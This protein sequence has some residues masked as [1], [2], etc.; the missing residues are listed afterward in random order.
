[1][2]YLRTLLLMS[3]L[4]PFYAFG[5][6]PLAVEDAVSEIEMAVEVDTSN[7]TNASNF[8]NVLEAIKERKA[9]VIDTTNFDIFIDEA[10]I[11]SIDNRA[12][13]I[14]A[15][16]PDFY[17]DASKY[18]SM[19]S[20]KVS[21]SENFYTVVV[22]YRVGEYEMESTLIN[23][24]SQGNIIA[25]QLVAYDEIEKGQ[26]R[27]TSRIS[28]DAITSQHSS[29]GLTKEIVVE[30]FV[31]NHDGTINKRESKNLSDTIDNDALV[32]YVLK[33]IGLAPP[34]LKTD[35]VVSKLNP[36]TPNEVIVVIPE[37][38]DE[39]EEYFELNSHIV[40]ADNRSG[41]VSHHFFESSQTNE[42]YSDAIRLKEIILDMAPYRVTDDI[43][44]FGVRVRYVGMSRV[45][46][47]E[48]ETLTLFIKSGDKLEKILDKYPVRNLNGE[49][50]G[51]CSGEFT[52]TRKTLI[53]SKQ[54]SKGFY[55]ILLKNKIKITTDNVSDDGECNS[56]E[57]TETKTSVLK[58]NGKK[59]L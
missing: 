13:H 10:D 24:D 16:Y 15:V 9:P 27:T 29:W 37:V 47:Y 17:Q 30:E 1:M 18:R 36:E 46:H 48:N 31:I 45:N 41:K 55:N 58:F 14:E 50:D 28:E 40:I 22:T 32:L 5:Q 57:K 51:E 34:S 43:R 25:H 59:Y 44:A 42:W 49:W 6:A 54:Q 2:K 11:K 3:V 20:Y 26:T 38:V 35:L 8:Q 23:Y 53:M 52:E 7:S 56:N 4:V 21:L 39:G 19:T 12:L 33:E